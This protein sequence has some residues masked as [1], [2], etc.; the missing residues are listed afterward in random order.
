MISIL[1]LLA[2]AA[3]AAASGLADTI[4]PL[5]QTVNVLFA[6]CEQVKEE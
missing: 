1:L 6:I 4:F 3:P 5:S 2:G